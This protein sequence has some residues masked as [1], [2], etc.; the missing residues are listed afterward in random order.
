MRGQTLSLSLPPAPA[1]IDE[2]QKLSADDIQKVIMS[3]PTKSCAFD[4]LPTHVIKEFLSELLPYITDMH[5][6]SLSQGTIPV[7]QRHAIITPRLKKSGLDPTDMKNYRPIS[8]LTFMSK[9]WRDWSAA[10]SQPFLDGI[11]LLP[12]SS[13][14]IVVIIR[15][16]CGTKAA[17]IR[18]LLHC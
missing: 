15:G 5:N 4:P 3:A 6:A 12:R 2:F 1:T 11:T 8:N 7:S 18:L 17:H 13:P 16:D 10:K 9:L 14:H